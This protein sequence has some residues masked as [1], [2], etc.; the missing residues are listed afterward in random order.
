ME[1]ILLLKDGIER[2]VTFVEGET[3]LQAAEKA[4]IPM[5]AFCEGQGICGGCHVIIEN[6][7]DKL[8]PISEDEQDRLDGVVGANENS[9]LSCQIVLNS[10]LNGLRVRINL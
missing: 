7:H 5:R 6:L 1:I 2:K 8:P 9:R 4:R 3:I 10:S